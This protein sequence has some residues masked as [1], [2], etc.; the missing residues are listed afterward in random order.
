MLLSLNLTV[1]YRLRTLI[2]EKVT[3]RKLIPKILIRL[4]RL[5][6][7]IKDTV[8]SMVYLNELTAKYNK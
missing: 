7:C 2:Q 8:Y 3:H 5:Q 6:R 4:P 1:D